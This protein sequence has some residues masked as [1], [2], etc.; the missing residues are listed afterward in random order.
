MSNNTLI[1]E[2][3]HGQLKYEQI[4]SKFRIHRPS[5]EKRL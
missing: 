1:K 5:L 3:E 4:D 2:N